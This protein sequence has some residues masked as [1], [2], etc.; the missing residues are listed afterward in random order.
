MIGVGSWV[1]VYW[2]NVPAE[3]NV[4]VSLFPADPASGWA[5]LRNDGSEIFVNNFC[6]I[7]EIK[8]E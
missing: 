8:D 4:M 7:E 3:F 5:F 6:K 1:N 2:E